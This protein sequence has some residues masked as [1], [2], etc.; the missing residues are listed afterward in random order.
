MASSD[1]KGALLNTQTEKPNHYTSTFRCRYLKEFRVEQC[2]SFLQ[3][4]CNQ[5]RPFVCFNWHFMNQR[6][7]R[8]V[9]RRD[10]SFN[11]SADNYCT[12]Y[13]ET[14]GICP[15]GDDCPF[16]HRTA[17][18][19][20]RRYHL[21]Y[22]KTCMCVHDTDAR[23]YCV[24]NGHHC[25]FAHGI[26]DQRP[27]VYDIK[28]LEALQAAEASGECLNGPNVLDKERNLMNEDPKWQDTNYVL[29]NYKTEPC[30]RPP[31]L[32]RQGYACPQYHNSK[33]KR[34]SPRKYKY[35]STPCPNVK[36]GEEWGEPANCEAGDN[37]QY[38]HTRTEQQFHPEIYK[39]TKCNDVQQAG[40]CPRSVFCAFAHVEPYVLTEEMGRDLD[41]QALALSDMI[42]SVLPPDSGGGGL[43]CPLSKKDKHEL[44]VSVLSYLDGGR[45]EN[46]PFELE[47]QNF[48]SFFQLLQ[49]GSAES[50]ES[51]STSSLGSNHSSHNKAPGSQLQQKHSNNL[52]GVA[53]CNGSTHNHVNNGIGS[54]QSTLFN[55]GGTAA[56]SLLSNNFPEFT[57]ELRA[58]LLAI[59]NDL[60]MGPLE[61]EQRK[62]MCLTFNFRNIASSLDGGVSGIASSG[63]LA[64][65]SAPVNIPG[66]PM[67]NSIS[68]LLQGTSAPVNIPGSSLSN[69]FSPSSHSNLFGINDSMFGSSATHHIGSSSAPKLATSFGHSGTDSLFFQS[70]IISPVLTGGDGGLSA[71]PELSR[72]SELNSLNNELSNNNTNLLFD[73]HM[74]QAAAAVQQ[75]QQQQQQQQQ[76]HQQ[77]HHAAAAAMA[78]ATKNSNSSHPYSMS[79]L[80]ASDMG[81]LRDELANKNAQMINWEEQVMQ[82]TNACE[83]WKAQMEESNRKTVIAEQQRDEALSHVKA[84]KEKLEH[85]NIGG[86][87]TS[88][89]RASDLRGMP[90]QKLKSIQAKL[91]SEIEEVEKVLYLETAT[92]C[93][94]CE[95]NNRSV[96]L[97]PC[98]HYVLCDSCATT[99]R[100][101]PYCQTPVSSQT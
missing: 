36:H 3:H 63:L 87:C 70:H 94:K 65:S 83:A 17:G 86:N 64:S 30:K 50:S 56:S 38:C 43:G 28:E 68:G 99:Q 91:R 21:R 22:Y 66:S 20:E 76:Q 13:D 15:D 46:L 52:I 96:T 89:Y 11:Y 18:D 12:K 19:T 54:L 45:Q 41:S 61:K 8:P 84:L 80:V 95:E 74:Q 92:K 82:A 31:R 25:A 29:A 62:R 42:S 100:E 57:P 1:P 35:R 79:P 77:Q 9:R 37:C 72:I 44:A 55:N 53:N 75:H 69:N 58:Q 101:C 5:H 6:R 90:L 23:G 51:A 97:V 67:G 4:K 71:S 32:C 93:M 78:A 24:K 49:N 59:D 16:L 81:R 47:P 73:N 40:Y 26:H 14:T 2:P 60:T 48:H 98:N 39:S 34:R 27:P 88:N 33:D 85:L 7:R 10:G